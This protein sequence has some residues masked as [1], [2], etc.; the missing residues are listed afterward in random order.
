[1][2]CQIIASIVDTAQVVDQFLAK[3][4][5][6]TLALSFHNYSISIKNWDGSSCNHV[7]GYCDPFE[8]DRYGFVISLGYIICA[9]CFLPLGLLNLKVCCVHF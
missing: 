9:V 4:G 8:S 6:G 1:M 2:Q 5:T 3:M 7:D